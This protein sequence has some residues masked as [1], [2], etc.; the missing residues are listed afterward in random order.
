MGDIVFQKA[1]DMLRQYETAH[2][3]RWPI[4]LV[5]DSAC[6]LPREL[7]DRYQVHVVPLRL[8]FGDNPF[9]DKVTITPDQFY[10]MLD[11]RPEFPRTA[12]PSP[13]D[14][15]DSYARLAG[16]YDSIIA[17]HL[18]GKLS[19]TFSTSQAAAR[20]VSERTGKRITVVDSRTLSGCLGLLVLRAARLV[21]A[22]RT[23]DEVAAAAAEMAPRARILVGVRTLKYLVRG[24]RVGPMAGVAARAL[25]LKPIVTLAESGEAKIFGPAFSRRG[26][27]RKILRRLRAED[28]AGRLGDYCV[29]HAHDPESARAY[30]AE[31]E[32]VLGR[33]PAYIMD[34]SPAIGLNAGVG[35]VA[36]SFLLEG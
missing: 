18:A 17:L 8:N 25:N 15:E 32:R 22:G 16:P 19:G 1:D 33:G 11:E 14:F 31:I 6:D 12:Q 9:L 2:A 28:R 30:A 20:R 26:L 36:V 13:K 29:L 34:I 23:H 10:R 27:L 4:A 24:G 21:E 5:T 35:A 3:R 7:L